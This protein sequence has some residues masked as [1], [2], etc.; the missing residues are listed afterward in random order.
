MAR[1]VISRV[2]QAIIVIWIVTTFVFLLVRLTPGNAAQVFAGPSATQE[3]IDLLHKELGLDDPIGKQYVEYMSR[4]VRGDFRDSLAQREPALPL[5][6]HRFPATLK[7]AALAFLI[8]VGFGGLLGV[9]SALY[10]GSPIDHF[11]RFFAVL[12]QSMPTFWIAILAILIFSVKLRWLPVAGTGDWKH[13]IL[14]AS[15]LGWFSM[16]AMVRLTRSAMLDVM[17][18]DSVKFLRI[19]GLSERKIV[20]KHALRNAAIPL[21]TLASLQFVAFLSGSVVVEQ[22]FNWPGS[23]KLLVES[24]RG[25]DYTVVQAGTFFISFVIVTVNLLVDLTYGYID[26]RIRH[27]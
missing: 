27:S 23:G 2:I 10:P 19:K 9:L 25:R 20:L 5:V 26:P 8:S 14:P 22:I 4:V 13:Y 15:T 21:L 16:A 11:G 18:S 3:Q 17:E 1:Y 7:L 12:G 6:L 24:V